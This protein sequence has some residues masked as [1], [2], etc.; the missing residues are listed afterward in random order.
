MQ[1]AFI[2]FFEA[3]QRGVKILHRSLGKNG[4]RPLTG[5][6]KIFWGHWKVAYNKLGPSFFCGKMPMDE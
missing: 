5:F 6:Q 2:K 4:L 3:L 1:E